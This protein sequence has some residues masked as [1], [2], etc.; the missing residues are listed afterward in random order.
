ML[1]LEQYL[2]FQP[3]HERHFESVNFVLY[4]RNLWDKWLLDPR[5]ADFKALLESTPE[6]AQEKLVAHILQPFNLMKEISHDRDYWDFVSNAH[7]PACVV[8]LQLLTLAKTTNIGGC[9]SKRLPIRCFS[10]FGFCDDCRC[11]FHPNYGSAA[12]FVICRANEQSVSNLAL[13]CK[14]FQ[15]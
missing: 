11:V 1:K 14:R 8:E 7:I 6:S 3:N 5:N 15:H 10:W 2:R 9:G 4:A 13:E 12:D